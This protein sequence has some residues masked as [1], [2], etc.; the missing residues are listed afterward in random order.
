MVLLKTAKDGVERGGK[1]GAG[2]ELDNADDV[3]K[4]HF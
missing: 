4:L 3:S 1:D 2:A